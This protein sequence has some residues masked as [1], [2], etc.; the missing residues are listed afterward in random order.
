M[1][2]INCTRSNAKKVLITFIR[3]IENKKRVIL[4]EV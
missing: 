2:N 1:D 4:K 3:N